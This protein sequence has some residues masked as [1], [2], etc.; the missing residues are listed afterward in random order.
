MKGLNTVFK[1]IVIEYHNDNHQYPE[2]DVFHDT[3]G[4]FSSRNEA[5]QAMNKYE[6]EYDKTQYSLYGFVIEQYEPDEESESEIT[7]WVY[8]A[9]YIP[10]DFGLPFDWKTMSEGDL[11]EVLRENTVT[12]ETVKIFP[13]PYRESDKKG[14]TWTVLNHPGYGTIN[15]AG[16]LSYPG[17]SNMFT[18]RFPVSDYFCNILKKRLLNSK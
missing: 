1:L 7:E 9:S 3:I 2:F 17:N 8:R 11:V 18:P 5:E 6:E 13:F 14:N 10:D 15:I 16:K 12:L 4:C